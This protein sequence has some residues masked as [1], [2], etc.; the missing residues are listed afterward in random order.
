M[1]AFMLRGFRKSV[2]GRVLADEQGNEM[3]EYALIIGLIVVF[4]LTCVAAV[5]TK[6]LAQW[7]GINGSV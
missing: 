5:G 7:A 1:E 3:I 4:C 6:V 2:L